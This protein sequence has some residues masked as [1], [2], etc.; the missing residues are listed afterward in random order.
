[1]NFLNGALLAGIATL[2]IPMI[3]HPFHQSRFMVVKCSGVR[4]DSPALDPSTSASFKDGWFEEIDPITGVKPWM[5]D[6]GCWMLDVDGGVSGRDG[7]Q[8]ESERGEVPR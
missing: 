1:M 4:E 6:V 7:I 5:L 8:T 3:I 2:S